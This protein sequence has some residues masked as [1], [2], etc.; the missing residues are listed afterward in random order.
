[1]PTGIV[2]RGASSLGSSN[3]R[4]AALALPSRM[5]LRSEK[6]SRAIVLSPQSDNFK[7]LL[8][9]DLSTTVIRLSFRDKI[10]WLFE[11]ELPEEKAKRAKTEATQG[12][13]SSG[14]SSSSSS[15][16]SSYSRFRYHGRQSDKEKGADSTI[17]QLLENYYSTYDTYF[18]TKGILKLLMAEYLRTHNV[19]L[20][21]ERSRNRFIPNGR[22]YS[23]YGRGVAGAAR[24]IKALGDDYG[25]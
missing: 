21:K 20:K 14:G 23:K 1:L 4:D 7:S 22:S 9:T 16:S 6:I 5:R 3:T 19:R 13:G 17:P 11:S 15:S 12:D 2:A 18:E 24:L 8:F 10:A 25:R